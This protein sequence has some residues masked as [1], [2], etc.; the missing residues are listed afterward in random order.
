MSGE[1]GCAC[2]LLS[3]ASSSVE[4]GSAGPSQDV[5]SVFLCRDCGR[6]GDAGSLSFLLLVVSPVLLARCC[7][8]CCCCDGF[9]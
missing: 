8:C 1:S 5:E 6:R 9:I 2:T 4:L 7:C 3:G